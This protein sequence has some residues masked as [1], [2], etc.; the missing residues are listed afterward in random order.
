MYDRRHRRR[1]RRNADGELTEQERVFLWDFFEERQDL[2]SLLLYEYLEEDL[3]SLLLSLHFA[4]DSSDE[5]S[6][7]DFW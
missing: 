6:D 3:S 7:Y 5:E 4:T 2:E 1:E